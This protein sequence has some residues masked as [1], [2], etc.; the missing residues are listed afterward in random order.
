M[1]W[2]LAHTSDFHPRG[3]GVTGRGAGS[4]G[5]GEYGCVEAAPPAPGALPLDG[6]VSVQ[7]THCLCAQPSDP[8]PVGGLGEQTQSPPGGCP[9]AACSP[10]RA[11]CE[12]Q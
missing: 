11:T 9:G 8:A 5:P 10:E 3:N 12:T 7:V 2:P 6:A 1:G 4:H